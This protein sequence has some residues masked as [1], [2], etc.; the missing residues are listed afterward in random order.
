M[1]RIISIILVSIIAFNI[2]KA[3]S[4]ENIEGIALEIINQ[5]DFCS[6]VTI[7]NNGYPAA[8]MMQTLPV[9][10][11]F[12]IWLG[13]KPNTQKVKQIKTN[14]KVSVYYTEANSTG[15]V[16]VKG[17]AEIINNRESKNKFW[18]EGWETFYPNKEKDF[19]LIKIKPHKLQIVSY[20]N[21]I[22]SKEDDWRAVEI[23]F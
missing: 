21:R 13:T 22:V 17:K 4:K 11:D 16:N 12:F 10:D 14:S 15:Y 23:V 20:E 3:Q 7:D 18:K 5:A 19:V 8:R 2:S 1:T 9:E 6:L